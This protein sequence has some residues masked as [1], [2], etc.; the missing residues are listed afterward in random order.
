MD[1]TLCWCPACAQ[2]GDRYG[3]RRKASFRRQRPSTDKFGALIIL[4][5]FSSLLYQS[6]R[7]L[8]HA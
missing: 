2:L 7:V 3:R 8:Y 4:E 1:G 5:L 6:R